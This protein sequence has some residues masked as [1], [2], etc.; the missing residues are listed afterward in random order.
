MI[1]AALPFNSQNNSWILKCI[2]VKQLR[3]FCSSLYA[4]TKLNMFIF[5]SKRD[6]LGESVLRWVDIAALTSVFLFIGINNETS[7]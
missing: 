7:S 4:F 1:S 6:F 5:F 3:G 2:E